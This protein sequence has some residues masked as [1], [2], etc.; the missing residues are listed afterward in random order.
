MLARCKPE[1]TGEVATG[2]EAV[3]VTHRCAERRRRDQADAAGALQALAA[4]I[5]LGERLQTLFNVDH[6]A[7]GNG[8]R[9]RA[10][11]LSVSRR[12]IG[13]S[14]SASSSAASTA[15][16]TLAEPSGIIDAE[17]AQQVA[18]EIDCRSALRLV[19]LAN[20]MQSL[21]TLL[22]AC[23]DRHATN[24]F[25]ACRFQQT[26]RIGAIGLVAA[27]RTVVRRAPAATRRDARNA[28]SAAP[29]N[30]PSRTLPSPCVTDHGCPTPWHTQFGSTDVARGYARWHT[31]LVIFSTAQPVQMENTR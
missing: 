26:R 20:A 15:G 24:R 10:D 18:H 4:Q 30:V 21:N 16:R 17:F 3:E 13:N 8:D 25:A 14:F 5:A 12:A 9:D 29:S 27:A 6:G 1:G 23:L 2:R 7:L 19:E 28:Q 11:S 22:L 31:P